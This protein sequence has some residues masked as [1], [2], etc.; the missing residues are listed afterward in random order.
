MFGSV[1]WLGWVRQRPICTKKP[2][3]A[4]TDDL[5]PLRSDIEGAFATVFSIVAVESISSL[6]PCNL[7]TGNSWAV[8]SA[9]ALVVRVASLFVRPGAKTERFRIREILR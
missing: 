6:S 4:P 7:V 3:P 2:G 9:A 1:Y 8:L 5:Q